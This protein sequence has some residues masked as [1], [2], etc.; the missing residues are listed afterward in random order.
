MLVGG[1]PY[2]IDSLMSLENKIGLGVYRVYTLEA[3]ETSFRLFLVKLAG[4]L[5]LAFHLQ[6]FCV[7]S[8][9]RP[10]A[11]RKKKELEMRQTFPV[12]LG[13]QALPKLQDINLSP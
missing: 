6:I 4:F 3:I 9:Y 11:R 10:I 7:V 12:V 1:L 2:R 5:S 8:C 13:Q